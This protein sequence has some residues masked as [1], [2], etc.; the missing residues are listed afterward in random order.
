MESRDEECKAQKGESRQ[1]GWLA[2]LH[3]FFASMLIL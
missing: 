3:T 2:L 1:V